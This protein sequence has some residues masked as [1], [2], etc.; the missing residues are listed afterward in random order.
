MA[1]SRIVAHEALGVPASL[2]PEDAAAGAWRPKPHLHVTVLALWLVAV[3]WFHP[4]LALEA[5][6]PVAQQS[7]LLT[8]ASLHA[9]QNQHQKTIDAMREWFRYE[10]TPSAE[11]HVLVAN[12][13][14]QLKKPGSA[15]LAMGIARTELGDY[16]DALRLFE[17]A[18]NDEATSRQAAPWIAYTRERLKSRS[19]S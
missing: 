3:V 12:A 8:L 18:A 4:A 15:P 19:R 9:T 6:H 11:A 17:R 7:T 16:G 10:A 5:L 13:Y 1:R 2:A 14:V